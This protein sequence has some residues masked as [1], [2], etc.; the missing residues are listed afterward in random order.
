MATVP[1][2][3]RAASRPARTTAAPLS[4]GR[5]AHPRGRATSA[6]AHAGATPAA[7]R[8]SSDGGRRDGVDLGTDKLYFKIGEVAA[9]VGV[10][11]HVLRYWEEEFSAIKPQRSRNQQRVYRR[12][13][14]LTLLRIK[15]LLHHQR[16]TIAGARKE[17][18]AGAAAVPMAPPSTSFLAQ[19]SWERVQA[20]VDALAGELGGDGD[21]DPGLADPAGFL[22]RVGGAR[23]LLAAQRGAGQGSA[24]LLDRPPRTAPAKGAVPP[25]I[26]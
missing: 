3:P 22:R 15:H 26:A 25:A 13:D 17:L 12:K 10:A 4:D 16:F 11:P 8:E 24:P 7:T 6:D 1:S 9:I 19:Q 18:R 14:V 5:A 20:A 21:R 2:S 23:G